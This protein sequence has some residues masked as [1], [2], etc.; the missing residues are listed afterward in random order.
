MLFNFGCTFVNKICW[1]GVCARA[2]G[3]LG[4]IIHF[5]L[6]FAPTKLSNA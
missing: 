4:Q 1:D 3:P 6:F 2:G 5:F